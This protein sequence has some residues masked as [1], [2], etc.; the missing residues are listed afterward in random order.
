MVCCSGLVEAE[1]TSV[2]IASF[3]SGASFPE[4]RSIAG[5]EDEVV[6]SD[7]IFFQLVILDCCLLSIHTDH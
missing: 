2:V 4:S 3:L 6:D 5:V 7:V 1:V